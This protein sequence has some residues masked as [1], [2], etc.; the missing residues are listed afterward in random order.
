[1]FKYTFDPAS[2]SA[3]DHEKASYVDGPYPKGRKPFPVRRL[4]Q[5]QMEIA[6]RAGADRILDAT[7][8]TVYYSDKKVK[9]VPVEGVLI[10]AFVFKCEPVAKT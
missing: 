3:L 7:V 8:S 2:K 9:H 10:P 6:H 4:L 1:M 5:Q